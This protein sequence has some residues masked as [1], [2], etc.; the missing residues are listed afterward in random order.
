MMCIQ[1]GLAYQSQT[2]KLRKAMIN[3]YRLMTLLNGIVIF[4]VIVEPTDW[5][6]S[7]LFFVKP[8]VLLLLVIHFNHESS[9]CSLT[10]LHLKVGFL[11][12]GTMLLKQWISPSSS[13]Q[14]RHFPESSTAKNQGINVCFIPNRKK[15]V[16]R[17]KKK[18]IQIGLLKRLFSTTNMREKNA[19]G[20]TEIEYPL[21]K[22]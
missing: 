11:W 18:T 19:E 9:R 17:K 6:H 2:V 15:A 14:K 10:D 20:G 4:L 12:V 8:S 7:C 1:L 13:L 3:M 22:S 21:T 16:V 5:A